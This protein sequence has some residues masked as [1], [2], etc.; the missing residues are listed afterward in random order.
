MPAP[1]ARR[2]NRAPERSGAATGSQLKE[3]GC[4]LAIAQCMHMFSGRS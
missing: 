2:V 1:K 4:K 3:A